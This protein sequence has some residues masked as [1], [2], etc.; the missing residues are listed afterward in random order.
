MIDL[1]SEWLAANDVFIE[2]IPDGRNDKCPCGCG[3]K[4]KKIMNN[5]DLLDIHFN[6]FMVKL[7]N[8]N[9]NNEEM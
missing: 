1:S 7:N 8:N 2:S 3:L 9:N 5:N 6:Q 4:W